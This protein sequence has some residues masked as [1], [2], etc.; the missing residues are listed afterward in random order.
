MKTALFRIPALTLLLAA[1]SL[2]PATAAIVTLTSPDGKWSLASDEFGAYGIAANNSFARR[3]FGAGLLDY[4]WASSI[5]LTEGS[6][7]QW[8]TGIDLEYVGQT[9]LNASN[10]ISDSTAGTTRTSAYNVPA[11]ANL[12]IDLVQTVTDAGITQ[13]YTFTNNRATTLNLGVT[14][15]HDVD[16][17]EDNA[18]TNRIALVNGTLKVSESGRD[19]YFAPGSTGYA[20]YLAAITTINGVT[21]NLD[22]IVFNGHGFPAGFANSFRDVDNLMVGADADTNHDLISDIPADVGYLFQNNLNIP[23]GG[24]LSFTVGT[25]LVPEPSSALLALAGLGLMARRRR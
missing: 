24:S 6:A 16:L 13:K 23:A 15:Y 10:V 19:L 2:A 20:G 14:S 25:Q 8:V 12:R 21:T 17:D 9:L 18:G 4:S 5:F 1:A 3:D 11:F 22:D 7:R